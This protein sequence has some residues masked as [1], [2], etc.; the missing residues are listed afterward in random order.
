[1]LKTPG[2]LT[3]CQR[4]NDRRP[5]VPT[6]RICEGWVAPSWCREQALGAMRAPPCRNTAPLGTFGSSGLVTRTMAAG[7]LRCMARPTD[8]VRRAL[9]VVRRALYV[10]RCTLYVVRCT[11]CVCGCRSSGAER[12]R[13]RCCAKGQRGQSLIRLTAPAPFFICNA[14]KGHPHRR[15]NK[16]CHARLPALQMRDPKRTEV[17]I[18]PECTGLSLQVYRTTSSFAP[19]RQSSLRACSGSVVVGLGSIAVVPP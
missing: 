9:Y 1:L 15:G 17:T 2:P 19:P 7:A 10:V 4:S 14:S 11:F 3:I 5:R 18:C 16:G 8:A 6:A 12:A 13:R